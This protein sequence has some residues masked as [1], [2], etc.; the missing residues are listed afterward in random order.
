MN[1]SVPSNYVEI[2]VDDFEEFLCHCADY[3][4][5][6]YSNAARYFFRHNEKVF[7]YVTGRDGK[8]TAF[9]DPQF[10]NQ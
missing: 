10:I 9:I 2:G 3:K 6:W 4:R 8:E 7:A 5:D 1:I